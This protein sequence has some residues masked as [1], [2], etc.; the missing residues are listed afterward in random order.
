MA[1]FEVLLFEGCM[2]D[3]SEMQR[4]ALEVKTGERR[5]NCFEPPLFPL[6]KRGYSISFR[7]CLSGTSFT[8]PH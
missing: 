1:L 6:S 2:N 3:E 7:L 4:V 8:I 5:L